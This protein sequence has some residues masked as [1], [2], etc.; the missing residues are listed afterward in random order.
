MEQ[1]TLDPQPTR[2]SFVD[3]FLGTSL[4]AVFLSALFPAF[5][6]VI[7]PEVAEAPTN[8]VHA[9][10]L[11]DLPPG[12]GKVFRFGSKPGIVVRT[13][14]GEVRA[15]TAICTHLNC[16]VQF[17]ED[18]QNIWCACHNGRFDLNGVNIAGPPPRP[19]ERY[20]VDITDD[21]IWVTKEA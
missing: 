18:M 9:A 8:T 10:N 7:P 14:T 17:R 20:R 3:W 13:S 5:R 6:F 4:G 15:F 19:L 21:E 12:S 16:T 11:A 2:R 1:Q